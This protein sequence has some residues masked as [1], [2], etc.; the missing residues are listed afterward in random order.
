MANYEYITKYDSPNFGFP[1]GAKGQNKPERIIIH[2][3]G[4]DGYSFQGIIN[5]MMNPNGVSAH[6]IVEGGKVACMVDWNNAAWHAGSKYWNTHSIGIEC[7]PEMSEADMQTVAEVIAMLWKEYGKLPLIGHK[8]VAPTACPGRWYGQLD[9]LTKMAE[10]IYNGSK[11]VKPVPQK[12]TPKLKIAVDGWWGRDTSR[13]LQVYFKMPV[14]DGIMS[15]QYAPNINA[16]LWRAHGSG[17]QFV[18]YVSNTGSPTIRAL[19]RL[20]GVTADG[21]VGINTIRALQRFLGVAVDGIMG[22]NTVCALQRWLN[23]KFN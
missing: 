11:P 19:Q 16:C 4:A 9:T 13:A 14:V 10:A 18:S 22:H 1:R 7:R 8:D 3:W 21:V 5:G 20:L 2:H 12:P 23:T 17:W 15:N 6:F